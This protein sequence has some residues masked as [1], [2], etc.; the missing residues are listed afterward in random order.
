[1]IFRATLVF[2]VLSNF[3]LKLF[4]EMVKIPFY[5]AFTPQFKIYANFFL[6]WSL[7]KSCRELNSKQLLFLGHFQKSH[8]IAQNSI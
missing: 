2:K 8:F 1:M 5:L 6:S 7:N 4:L 3:A